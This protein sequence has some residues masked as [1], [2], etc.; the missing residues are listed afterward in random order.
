MPYGNTPYQ[1]VRL[2]VDDYQ[3]T[4]AMSTTNSPFFLIQ[5]KRHICPV[6]VSGDLR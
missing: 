4:H 6:I 5:E 1:D 3:I 2:M